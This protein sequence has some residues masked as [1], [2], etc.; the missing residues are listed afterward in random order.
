MKFTELKNI[1]PKI[2]ESLK[3]MSF[4]DL[5]KIQEDTIS[6]YLENKDQDIIAQ[7]QTGTGKTAAF[8]IPILNELDLEEKSTQALI[9]APTREL[10][11]QI[12]KQIQ[13][14]GEELQ[15]NTALILGGVS[16]D[17]Q[18]KDISKRPKIIIGTPGRINDLLKQKHLDISKIRFFVLDEADE[19]LKIGFKKEIEEIISYLPKKRTNFFFT[20]TFDNKTKDLANIITSNAETIQVSEGLSTSKTIE[21]FFLISNEKYKL[22]DLVKFLIY[23]NVKSAIIFGRTKRRVDQLNDAINSLGIKSYAIQG[24][25]QQNDRN[26]VMS[27]FRENNGGILIATDVVSR[28]IDID[29]VDWVIN[30]DLPQEIEYYT[31]RIGRVG[32]A[33]RAGFSVSFVK[34]D[35]IEHLNEIK[36]RTNSEIERLMLPN[37]ED[38]Q[39]FWLKKIEEKHRFIIQKN[40]S[41]ETP[42]HLEKELIDNFSHEELAIILTHYILQEKK[43]KSQVKLTPEPSVILKGNAKVRSIKNRVNG[44]FKYRDSNSRSSREGSWNKGPSSRGDRDSRGSSSSRGDRDSRG[45]SYSRGDRDSRGSSSSRGDRDSRPSFSRDNRSRSESGGE[46]KSGFSKK[47][48]TGRNFNKSN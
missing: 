16:Y 28:G 34:Q 31:H 15:I 20:A 39:E 43:L 47:P 40:K 3:K 18:F 14:M 32:R 8:S 26:F 35:E 1:N 25:M 4:E 9:V 46:R 2:I 11:T 5:T 24:N 44:N 38:F 36:N 48:S 27:K 41:E 42:V 29:H 45:S 23:K 33:G 17:K 21:Q 7:A 10:A 13:R 30:F 6:S 22:N 19:L 12:N 37:D